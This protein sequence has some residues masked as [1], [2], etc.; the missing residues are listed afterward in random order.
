MA[1]TIPFGVRSLFVQSSRQL[2]LFYD[3]LSAGEKN[4]AYFQWNL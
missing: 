1:I 2:V 3:A 4:E